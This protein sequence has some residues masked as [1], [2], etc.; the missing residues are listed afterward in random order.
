MRKKDIK[1][2][3]ACLKSCVTGKVVWVC[4][5]TTREAARKAYQR[6]RRYE[7]ERVAHWGELMARKRENILLLLDRLKEDQPSGRA[8]P[9]EMRTA[10]R[11]IA[12][13]ANQ[14]RPCESA[15]YEH[16]A[17]SARRGQTLEAQKWTFDE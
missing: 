2:I 8:M 14:E 7:T 1:R 9:N 11:R 13:I 16:I 12:I 6:A 4:R 5:S 17:E 15:F 3:T 10:A